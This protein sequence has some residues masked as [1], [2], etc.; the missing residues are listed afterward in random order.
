[1]KNTLYLILVLLLAACSSN[2]QLTV[3]EQSVGSRSVTPIEPSETN[4]TLLTD[5]ENCTTIVLNEVSGG[6]QPK[7]VTAPWGNGVTTSLPHE[8]CTDIKKADGWKMLFHTF[9]KAN[10]DEKQA[11]MCFYNMFTGYMKFF[12]FADK[13]DIGTQTQWRLASTSEGECQGIF[14]DEAY[15]SQPINNPK[16]SVWSVMLANE[17]NSNNTGITA[18]WN[19][20][21]FRVGEYRPQVAPHSLSIRGYNTLFSSYNFLGEETSTTTGKITTINSSS[22]SIL[23]N[24]L[25]GGV[26]NQCGETAKET[27]DKI[28]TKVLPG[29]KILGLDLKKVVTDI[30]TGNYVGAIKAGLGLVFGKLLSKDKTTYS[31]SDVE[32]K[33]FGTIKLEGNSETGIESKLA[34]LSF[35]LNNILNNSNN[36]ARFD[37]NN[38]VLLSQQSGTSLEL[39]VWN[40]RNKPII[41]YDR[42]I[43]YEPQLEP[44]VEAPVVDL[45]GI[46]NYPNTTA[47]PIEVVFN[48][49]IQPYIKNYSTTVGVIDVV[50]G[51]RELDNKNKAI[52]RYDQSNILN[53]INDITIYGI[54]E[55]RD[56]SSVYGMVELPAGV[57]LNSDTEYY[58]DWGTAVGGYAAAVVTL[59]MDI[60]YMGQQ[61]SLTESRVYDVD[62]KPNPRGMS[63]SVAH[64]PPHTYVVNHSNYYGF[65]LY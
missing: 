62:Y 17:Q 37:D 25:V 32:L 12:Y 2:E 58:L 5:W 13:S 63:F 20:F 41:Y 22:E 10:K 28:A 24:A 57:T 14:D 16:H 52:I 48:P 7:S 29:K 42:Y 54:E 53:T 31:V 4:P 8:F 65:C 49:M 40:L 60:E 33:T 46:F 9:C 23:N 44:D 11:Y 50:G 21:Q 43:K 35:N 61:F 15:F 55:Q 3:P 34:P 30:G 6:G 45:H 38:M 26:L 27:V 39:G 51:N 64:N 59:T 36:A 47:G 1:M 18:G 19:G 56:E